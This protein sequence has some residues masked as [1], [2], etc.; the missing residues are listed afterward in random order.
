M[1]VTE[2]QADADGEEER[3]VVMVPVRLTSGERVDDAEAVAPVEADAESLSME[4]PEAAEEGDA[5]AEAVMVGVGDPVSVRDTVAVDGPEALAEAVPQD[6]VDCD[7]E[8]VSEAD[9]VA[10]P[11]PRALP[12]AAA[13][14]RLGVK[15]PDAEEAP[16]GE[17]VRLPL[18]EPHAVTAALGE[19]TSGVPVLLGLAK[20]L[21][22]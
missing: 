1:R 11:V 4:V 19:S 20:E 17:R 2:P 5:A 12:V 7:D 14:V 18:V 21:A 22:L 9:R 13:M 8:G 16:E 15:E 6:V 3:D 10:D